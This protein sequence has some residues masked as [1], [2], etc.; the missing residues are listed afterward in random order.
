MSQRSIYLSGMTS[1][2]WR[3]VR[4]QHTS[5]KKSMGDGC[6]CELRCDAMNG[7]GY[8][9]HLSG[10]RDASAHYH[11]VE[12]RRRMELRDQLEPVQCPDG[13]TGKGN[14]TY[15]AC[16]RGSLPA[17]RSQHETSQIRWTRNPHLRKLTDPA[18]VDVALFGAGG[19]WLELSCCWCW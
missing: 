4:C 19:F 12:S 8:E 6:C 9:G 13:A 14:L 10:F 1:L 15:L 5:S 17:S 7:S 16:S 3:R 11:G 18:D 2:A